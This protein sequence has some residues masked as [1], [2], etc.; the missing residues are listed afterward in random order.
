ML[1]MLTNLE[2]YSKTKCAQYWPDAGAGARKFGELSVS[3][4]KENRFADYLVREL[5]L[6]LEDAGECLA[7]KKSQR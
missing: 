5:R 4:I 7:K 1:L 2:E 3:H 6:R